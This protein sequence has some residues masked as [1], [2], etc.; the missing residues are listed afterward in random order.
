MLKVKL[1]KLLRGVPS[2]KF[3]AG[4]ITASFEI[5]VQNILACSEITWSASF[6]IEFENQISLCKYRFATTLFHVK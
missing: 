5:N 6:A 1:E 4:Q 3:H 2:N